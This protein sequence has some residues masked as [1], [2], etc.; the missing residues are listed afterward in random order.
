MEAIEKMDTHCAGGRFW[1]HADD[2]QRIAN[3]SGME[4]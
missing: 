2:R 3:V 4:L 1:K